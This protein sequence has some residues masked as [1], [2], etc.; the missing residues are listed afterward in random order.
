MFRCQHRRH[1]LYILKFLSMF[2]VTCITL[3][4][5]SVTL[6]ITEVTVF[7]SP[8]YHNLKRDLQYCLYY[9]LCNFRYSNC[10]NFYISLTYI[11]VLC[12]VKEIFKIFHPTN[13]VTQHWYPPIL[14]GIVKLY[15]KLFNHIGRTPGSTIWKYI[16]IW[17]TFK[18]N[19]PQICEW[20][21]CDSLILENYD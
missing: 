16:F 14:T 1:L 12:D 19:K 10:L 9:C 3:G 6:V 17:L 5:A 11:N 2:Y 15:F 7:S 13:Y 4:V 18:S 8:R 20:Y 21:G